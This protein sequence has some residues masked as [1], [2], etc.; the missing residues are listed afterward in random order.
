MEYVFLV[1]GTKKWHPEWCNEINRM[2]ILR[3]LLMRRIWTQ[4]VGSGQML[5]KC[6]SITSINH[7]HVRVLLSS[8]LQQQRS[9]PCQ[10]HPSN[11]NSSQ[12]PLRLVHFNNTSKTQLG[13]PRVRNHE[14]TATGSW[15]DRRFQQSEFHYCSQFW[16]LHN[17][18]LCHRVDDDGVLMIVK[19]P[20][21]V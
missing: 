3:V 13:Q 9:L 11:L 1:F 21:L 18:F 4:K 10:I 8:A 5:F 19:L 7:F 14:Q 15:D 12:S 17:S 2:T 16:R 20:N 6:S